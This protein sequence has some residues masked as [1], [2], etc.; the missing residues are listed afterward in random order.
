MPPPIAHPEYVVMWFYPALAATAHTR[1]DM[2]S[3]TY[4]AGDT[5]LR[6]AGGSG[7]SYAVKRTGA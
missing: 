2:L 7:L 5:Y 4:G 6:H 3:S 1:F